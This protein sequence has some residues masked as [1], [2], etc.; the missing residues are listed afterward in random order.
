MRN[1]RKL[2]SGL[3]A[4]GLL[5]PTDALAERQTAVE[6][7][8]EQ[9]PVLDGTFVIV[10]YETSILNETGQVVNTRQ[11]QQL[12][13]ATNGQPVP[14]VPV[15]LQTVSGHY[16][17]VLVPAASFPQAI[18]EVKA[19]QNV[20][21]ILEVDGKSISATP[22]A[23]HAGFRFNLSTRTLDTP[24]SLQDAREL[25]NALD[26][27][28]QKPFSD[29]EEGYSQAPIYML[30]AKGIIS[31]VG[32]GKFDPGSPVTRAAFFKMLAGLIEHAPNHSLTLPDDISA[33]PW[34]KEYALTVKA[35]LEAQ[36]PGAFDRILGSQAR[37]Q[38]NKPMTRAE[39][40]QL[41]AFLL[42][43]Q[44]PVGPWP[45]SDW[46]GGDE[47]NRVLH[48]AQN[49][50]IN[51]IGGGRYAPHSTLT[52]EQMATMIVRLSYV[53]DNS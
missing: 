4:L 53:T 13:P 1:T 44:Q 34:A 28:K 10:T 17:T 26:Y 27:R 16:A 5:F 30:A 37:L 45:F 38:P 42:K 14:T 25:T 43:P 18:E 32:G 20:V 2:L 36:S 19:A 31:G 24:W 40:A 8:K 3:L 46:D 47:T 51:G 15:K 7:V 39:A 41:M 6:K 52:R 9:S 23:N 22:Y 11:R 12:L 29:V 49:Q 50:V 33:A 35:V 48:L 21:R